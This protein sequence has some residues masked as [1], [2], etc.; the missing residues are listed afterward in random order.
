MFCS[1]F[2]ETVIGVFDEML[3]EK[4][5]D[6]SNIGVTFRR[7]VQ[8]PLRRMKEYARLS[9]KLAMSFSEVNL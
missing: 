9:S 2:L 5:V 3:D 7:V 8:I 6:K 4:K 1:A